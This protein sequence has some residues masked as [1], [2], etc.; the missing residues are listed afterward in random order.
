MTAAI[1]G[2]LIVWCVVSPIPALILCRVI[3][4][5]DKEQETQRI[6]EL[7]PVPAPRAW[8]EDWLPVW[9]FDQ[10]SVPLTDDEFDEF[11]DIVR[12]VA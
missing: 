7:P 6:T 10:P 8:D 2:A 5:A 9:L 3:R 1:L 4:R 12:G 11:Q